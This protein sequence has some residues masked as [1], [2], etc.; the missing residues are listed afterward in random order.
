MR[1]T[2]TE[3]SAIEVLDPTGR[4][5]RLGDIWA[6]RPTVAVWL[7][8]F[9]CPYCLEQ[10]ATLTAARPTFESEGAQLLLIGNGRPEQAL[11]FQQMRAPGATVVTDPERRSYRALGARR[12]LLGMLGRGTIRGWL[13][14]RRLGIKADGLQGDVLQLGGTL[15]VDPPGTVLLA[16]I[17]SGPGDHPSVDAIRC[18]LRRSALARGR[19]AAA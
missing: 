5:V 14:A 13:A 10:V 17:G 19:E 4:P 11:R 8:H 1:S 18:A 7:R 16:H 3:L 15:V 6:D 9:G 12:S 2:I